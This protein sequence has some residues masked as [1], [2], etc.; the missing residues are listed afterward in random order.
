MNSQRLF[1]TLRKINHTLHLAILSNA[2][3]ALL[4]LAYKSLRTQPNIGQNFVI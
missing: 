2:K 4:H 3:I 1:G